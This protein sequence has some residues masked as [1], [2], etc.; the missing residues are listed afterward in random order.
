MKVKTAHIT[1]PGSVETA[2][3]AI[4]HKQNKL[5]GTYNGSPSNPATTL[6]IRRNYDFKREFTRYVEENYG[7]V[8]SKKDKKKL[9]DLVG[10][11]YDSGCIEDVKDLRK[12]IKIIGKRN[13][14]IFD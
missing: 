2:Q 4:R 6:K 8:I 1:L 11:H 14:L 10:E 7:D 5:K 9:M 13:N 12:H 3:V